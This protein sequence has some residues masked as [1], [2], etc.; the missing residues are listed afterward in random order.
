MKYETTMTIV[1]VPCPD[2]KGPCINICYFHHD[3]R[4][5]IGLYRC[6]EC[7][8]VVVVY[9]ADE[10]PIA[11]FS[12]TNYDFSD[13]LD[14]DNSPIREVWERLEAEMNSVGRRQNDWLVGEQWD[15][16]NQEKIKYSWDEIP[17]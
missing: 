7:Q 10:M 11:A 2:C 1:R 17:F 5:Y 14:S 4:F 9:E 16:V 12:L 6:V 15:P 8:T 13:E 3:E